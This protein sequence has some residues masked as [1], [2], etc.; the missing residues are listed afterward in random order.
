MST[1]YL[2]W[3]TKYFPFYAETNGYWYPLFT[4]FNDDIFDGTEI[5]SEIDEEQ[6]NEIKKKIDLFKKNY[7]KMIVVNV[8]LQK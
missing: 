5:I 1:G 8:H 2:F 6:K 7:M 4:I 3:K